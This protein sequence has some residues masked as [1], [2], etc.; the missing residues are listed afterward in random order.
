M[1]H[2]PQHEAPMRRTVPKP[3]ANTG[4]TRVE[5]APAGARV[6]RWTLRQDNNAHHHGAVD[7]RKAPVY[8]D[9]SWKPGTGGPVTH[10]GVFKLD[11]AKL[12]D[13]QAI[14]PEPVGGSDAR[15]RVRVVMLG[16]ERFV[17]Q[18]RSGGPKASLR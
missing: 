1:Y 12:L 2:V 10:V 11:L 4:I 8:L 7:N 18:V 9:L 13:I 3:F 17:L 14:R 6:L 16:A 5:R 15:V